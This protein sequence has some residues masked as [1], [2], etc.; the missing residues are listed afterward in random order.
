MVAQHRG[1]PGVFLYRA[2]KFPRAWGHRRT[3]S[4]LPL[5]GGVSL[6]RH[7]HRWWLTGHALGQGLGE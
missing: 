5:A 6:V 7:N 3:L 1:R 2:S 4:R